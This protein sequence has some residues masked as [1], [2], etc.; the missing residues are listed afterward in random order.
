M[1][2][3]VDVAGHVRRIEQQLLQRFAAGLELMHREVRTHEDGLLPLRQRVK[4]PVLLVLAQRSGDGP[5]VLRATVIGSLQ[6]IKHDEVH[7]PRVDHADDPAGNLRGRGVAGVDLQ[8]GGAP[9]VVAH[10]DRHVDAGALQQLQLRGRT[11]VVLP[12]SPQPGEV[13][14]HDSPRRQRIQLKYLGDGG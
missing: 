1:V 13:S 9:V 14:E 8:K 4:D 11:L 6:A 12:M 2:M 10:A 7:R 5:H 3:P